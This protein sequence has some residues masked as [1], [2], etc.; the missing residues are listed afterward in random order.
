MNTDSKTALMAEVATATLKQRIRRAAATSLIIV[1]LFTAAACSKTKAT[2]Q[3]LGPPEVEVVTVEQKDVPI[4]SEWIGTLDGMVNAE[5][6]SQVTGY[7]LNKNYTEGSFVRK[8][9]LMFEIDPRP[10]QS[11][12]EQ[13]KGDLAKSQGQLGQAEALLLQAQAQLAQAQANQGK[14]QL[15][16]DRYTMLV[17]SGVINKQDY[18]NAVQ[19]NLASLAQ[20]KATEAGI[21]TASAGIESAK[22]QI[23][24]SEAALKSAEINLS[25]TKIIAPIDGIAG[26]ATVQ[27]GNLVNLNNPNSPPLTTVS[28]VDPIKA[29]FTAGEQDYQK[30]IKSSLISGARGKLELELILSDGTTYPQ[31]GQFYMADRSVDQ[32]TGA[33]KLAGLFPNPGNILRPG[34]YGRVRAVTSLKEGALVVPQ[35]AVTDLQGRYSVAVVGSD[36][37]VSI[38]EVR[39][40]DRVGSM[41]IIEE[42]LKAGESVVAEGTQKVR[43]DTAVIPKPFVA[44]SEGK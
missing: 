18:D 41:W 20:V 40:G 14:T 3:P 28:T 38:R 6:K 23:K 4:Y 29:Y 2:S 44:P 33:I 22:S 13:A 39:V 5:I 31:K 42:G 15:D 9:Q 32:K 19:A 43:P 35:R 17:K 30:Y 34:E 36:N 25:F 8:G 11:A 10:F 7:L 37:K 12:V 24:A 26:I 21:K 27:V 16:V 1:A